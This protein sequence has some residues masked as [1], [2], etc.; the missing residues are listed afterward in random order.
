M[1]LGILAGLTLAGMAHAAPPPRA[2]PLPKPEEPPPQRAI[3]VTPSAPPSTAPEPAPAVPGFRGDAALPSPAPN[4][5]APAASP[6]APRPPSATP[7]PVPGAPK[8]S[9]PGVV[10][11][12][13]VPFEAAYAH[14]ARE[15]WEKASQLYKSFVDQYPNSPRV[16]EAFF[17]LAEAHRKQGNS[18]SAKLFYSKQLASADPGPNAAIGAYTLAQLEY[19]ATDYPNALVHYRKAAQL[20]VDPSARRRAEYFSARCLQFLEKKSEA[21]AAFQPL[22]DAPEEHPF[23]ERSQYELAALLLEAAK[24][25]EALPR[26]AALAKSAKTPEIRAEAI[27]QTALLHAALERHKEALPLL[28]AALKT[29]GTEGRHTELRLQLLFSHSNLGNH[30][31]VTELFPAL[32]SQIPASLLPDTLGL[33]VVAH[34]GLKQHKE[35]LPLLDKLLSAAPDFLFKSRDS[36]NDRSAR[37]ERLACLYNLQ[38]PGIPA[39]ID[40]FLALNPIPQER[41]NA[42]LMRAQL[43]QEKG[44]HPRAAETYALVA[45]SKDLDPKRRTIALKQWYKSASEA[46]NSAQILECTSLF[47]ASDPDDEWA[48]ILRLAR[49]ETHY[50]LK[51]FPEAE[52][53]FRLL[54]QKHPKFE[55]RQNA[56]YRLA[57][58]R[59]SLKDAKGQCDF[60]EQ[61]L[62]EYPNSPF[63]AEAHHALGKNAFETKDYAKASL[64]LLESRKLDPKEYFESDTL[65]LIYCAHQLND[66]DA[67]LQRVKEFPPESQRRLRPD[68]LRW[69]VQQF[70]GNQKP[71]S[72]AK[73]EPLLSL[74]TSSEEAQ[75]S[76]WLQLAQTRLALEQFEQCFPAVDAYL[77]LASAPGPRAEGFL[78]RARAELGRKNHEAARTNVNEALKLQVNGRYHNEGV[79]LVGDIYAAQNQWEEAAKTYASGALTTDDEAIT[80]LLMEKAHKAYLQAGNSKEAAKFLNKLQSR[81]PEYHREHVK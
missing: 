13:D 64:H 52:K 22:A 38:S 54:V 30:A 9:S 28:E 39:E 1:K 49:A 5:A 45:K 36:K 41:N 74:I 68:I 24:N 11:E 17:F 60:Y 48:P 8:P 33:V 69:C 40:A 47:L 31:K 75:E 50:Q 66:P 78:I 32:E 15:N 27:S 80:P 81:Y 6:T 26:F 19:D 55:D 14:Y 20:I 18:N 56:L 21:R 51:N 3:P 25:T 10:S 4:S 12:E 79:L 71:S 42:L 43:L 44:D 72:H 34:L 57:W 63:K 29:P 7:S 46:Q 35:A 58:I 37:Y 53:D 16:G 59:S 73:A 70:L 67:L 61:L 2:V 76:D 65:A 77:K 23:Q 62:K